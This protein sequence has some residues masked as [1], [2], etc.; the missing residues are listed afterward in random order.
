MDAR[1]LGM[2]AMIPK[3]TEKKIIAPHEGIKMD[4]NHNPAVIRNAENK[5]GINIGAHVDPFS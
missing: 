4:S 1:N 2:I 5:V 3:P